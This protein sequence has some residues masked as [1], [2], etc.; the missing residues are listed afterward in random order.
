MRVRMILTAA[1]GVTMHIAMAQCSVSP[2]VGV[3]AAT[4]HVVVG[5]STDC[6]YEAPIGLGP[7]LAKFQYTGVTSAVP[8]GPAPPDFIVVFPSSGTTSS[9]NPTGVLIGLNQNVVKTLSPGSYDLAVNFSTVDQTP[10][11][12]FAA[13]IGL[14][15]FAMRPVVASIVN[16]ASFLPAISPGTIVSIFGSNF[17]P[18]VGATSYDDTGLYPTSLPD[19]GTNGNT[20]VTFNGIAAPMLYV[21]PGQINAIVP[22]GVAGQQTA[23]V[24]VTCYNLTATFSVPILDT[25]PAVFTA[26][27]N[28]A[29]QGAILNVEL[30][31]PVYNSPGNPSPKG[32]AITMFATGVGAWSPPVPEG[33]I[34]L[35]ASASTGSVAPAPLLCGFAPSCTRPAALISLTIGGEPAQILYTGSS[36]FQPWSLLQ[37]NAVV[38]SDTGSGQQPVVLT[39]G[40]NDNSQQK[41]TMAIQ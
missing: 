23:A 13:G 36:P 29:G 5:G 38:P 26:T 8:G 24:V 31:G 33:A 2:V 17:G 22:Y 27:Q 20:T 7:S 32:Y 37:I 21:G 9:S 16:A 30:V 39:V 18:P 14:Q 6:V 11:F 34:S 28:G 12:T 35:F 41:V 1:V 40:P 19:G 25:S 4:F 3:A 15:L 10:A